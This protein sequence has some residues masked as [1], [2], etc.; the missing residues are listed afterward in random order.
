MRSRTSAEPRGNPASAPAGRGSLW[1]AA[2]SIRRSDGLTVQTKRAV[3]DSNDVYEQEAD[4]VADEIARGPNSRVADVGRATTAS[5]SPAS[6][7][8]DSAIPDRSGAL[9]SVD[10]VLRGGGGRPLDAGTRSLMESRFGYDFTRVRV[11]SDQRA[12]ESARAIDA[13]AYTAG[14]NVVFGAGQYA[15]A[16]TE[17]RRLLAHE[18]AHVVQQS[19]SHDGARAT[20]PQSRSLVRSRST[21][22]AVQRDENKASAA[23]RRESL[24]A[25][26]NWEMEGNRAIGRYRNWLT[27]NMI[28]F[29][30]DLLSSGKGATAIDDMKGPFVKNVIQTMVGDAGSTIV[31]L[32]GARFGG[33]QLAKLFLTAGAAKWLGGIVGFVIGAIAETLI[34]ELLDQTNEIIRATAG[35]IDA[36]VTRVLNPIVDAKQQEMTAQLQELRTSLL[37]EGVTESEWRRAAREVAQSTDEVSRLFRDPG[38]E[39]LYR[40]LSLRADVCSKTSVP[41]EEKSPLAVGF[42]QDFHIRMQHRMVKTGETSILVFRDHGTVVVRSRGYDCMMDEDGAG[43]VDLKDPGGSP[44]WKQIPPPREYYLQLYQTGLVSESDVGVPREF[45][46]GKEETG[47]W[48][49]LPKG[50]YH[51]EAWRSDDHPVALCAEG[52]YATPSADTPAP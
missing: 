32:A 35:Q 17:G 42:E 39:S 44:S 10:T 22:R 3:G 15:P 40:Q 47:I 48:Y 9:D 16:S 45:H 26:D 7:R 28:L 24:N 6:G 21:S 31:K 43:P 29:L 14:V 41:A 5:P 52:T 37:G 13:R 19:G 33:Q 36:L 4:R 30:G 23:A 27:H 34:G 38:E 20:N 8:L 51:L 11:H 18:L 46:V 50:T 49:N 1:P 2:R 12:A 25:I